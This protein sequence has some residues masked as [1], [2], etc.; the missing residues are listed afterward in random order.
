VRGKNILWLTL[1][2]LL[3]SVSVVHVKAQDPTISVD[4]PYVS[5]L[6]PG[7]TFDVNIRIRD[8]V[9]VYAWGISMA[10]AKYMSVISVVSMSAGDFLERGG[11][12]GY[13]SPYVD[14]FNGVLK[15]G[16]TLIGELTPPVS[17]DGILCTITF[18][19]LEAGES[20]LDLYDTVLLTPGGSLVEVPHNVENG[21]YRG[22]TLDLIPPPIPPRP[23]GGGRAQKIWM[24]SRRFKVGTARE[25][26]ADVVADYAPLYYRI[27]YT[28][29]HEQTGVTY[30]FY[31]GQQFTSL[32]PPPPRDVYLYVNE[33]IP[34]FE[35][36]TLTG[37]SPYLNAEGDGSYITGNAYCQLS[38]LFGFDD[39]TLAPMEIITQVS[40]E[41]YTRS[42]HI[43]IDYD[44]YVWDSFAWLGS[45]WG[46][47]SW[48]WKSPRWTTRRVDQID[49]S[50]KTEAGLNAFMVLFHYWTPKG[51]NLGDADLDALRLKVKIEKPSVYPPAPATYTVPEYS[52]GTPAPAIWYLAAQDNGKWWTTITVEYRYAPP[53]PRFPIVWQTGLTSFTYEWWCYGGKD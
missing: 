34:V 7:D 26:T 38:D 1:I 30:T 50:T 20:P 9:N 24:D 49:P 39:I 43:D 13:G 33:H 21:Y 8:S 14:A 37:T 3:L 15:W 2:A 28:S 51:D 4:P 53:D 6:L 25:F 19:V 42:A 48:A 11:T 12:A 23:K 44:A 31:S 5:G 36:W 40:L 45:L 27:K 41:G 17:G 22:P 32:P 52:V 10:Y 35:E 47:T 29:V 16:A 46:E 18:V